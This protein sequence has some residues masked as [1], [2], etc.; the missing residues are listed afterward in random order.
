[1]SLMCQ[2]ERVFTSMMMAGTPC[3]YEGEIGE[4]ARLAWEDNI[5]QRP[6]KKAYLKKITPTRA[7]RKAAKRAARLKAKENG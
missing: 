3:P 6:D 4:A 1:V 2:D 5:A 7:E